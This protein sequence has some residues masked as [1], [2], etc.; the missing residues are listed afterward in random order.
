MRRS[1]KFE[2]I[3]PAPPVITMFILEASGI[4]ISCISILFMLTHAA[5]CP[6]R[7]VLTARS[8]DGFYSSGTV[9]AHGQPGTGRLAVVFFQ[10]LRA[11]L[12]GVAL[13][14]TLAGGCRNL[15][16]SRFRDRSNK[17]DDVLCVV[18]DQNLAC[19]RKERIEPHPA[20]ADDRNA[21]SRG[22]E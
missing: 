12:R 17:L 4:A 1:H 8:C 6:S 11:L 20:I 13:Q 18:C 2:P 22:L 10:L 16:P 19:R 14:D 15:L 9:F 5:R 21:A 3:K 7:T